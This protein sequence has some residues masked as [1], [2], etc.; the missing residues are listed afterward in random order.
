MTWIKF[1]DF[2]PKD[3]R[4]LITRCPGWNKGENFFDDWRE[5]DFNFMRLKPHPPTHWWR[6][7]RNLSLAIENWS[8]QEP[9][10][11]LPS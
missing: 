8:T 2:T 9:S 3:G 10:E 7:P 5:W 6:G 1:S 4:Y 11:P